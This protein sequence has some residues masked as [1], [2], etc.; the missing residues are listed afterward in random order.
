MDIA[1]FLRTS[2]LKNFCERLLLNL[3][4]VAYLSVSLLSRTRLNINDGTFL[5]K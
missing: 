4:D 1:K 2:I 3:G 5:Q